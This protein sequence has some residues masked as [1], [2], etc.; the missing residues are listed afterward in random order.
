MDTGINTDKIKRVFKRSRVTRNVY[1][2]LCNI[3]PDNA[4][5]KQI[6]DGTGASRTSV[7]GALNGLG[8]R[9]KAEHSLNRMGL[10]IKDIKNVNGTIT[11]IYA[12][13]QEGYAH[14]KEY[15]SYINEITNEEQMTIAEKI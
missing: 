7:T 10:L 6:C 1:V 3:Y 9:Y 13:S 4:T 8:S 15:E 2:Y 14:R 5:L 11:T 12:L